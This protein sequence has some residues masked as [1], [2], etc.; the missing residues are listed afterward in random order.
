[1]S[2][3]AANFQGA[4]APRKR[5]LKKQSYLKSLISLGPPLKVNVFLIFHQS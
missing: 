3:K 2:T 1:M 5:R 4:I